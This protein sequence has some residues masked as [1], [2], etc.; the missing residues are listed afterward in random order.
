MRCERDPVTELHK[1]W[2]AEAGIE[3]ARN[4]LDLTFDV[5]G[6]ERLTLGGLEGLARLSSEKPKFGI[7]LL[8][9]LLAVIVTNELGSVAIG[10]ESQFFGDE[11]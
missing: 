6:A 10:F 5:D 9:E 3:G 7:L 8:E 11:S 4:G 1:I 2:Q